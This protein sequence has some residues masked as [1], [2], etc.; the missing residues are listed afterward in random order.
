MIMNNF[1]KFIDSEIGKAI[2]ANWKRTP[3]DKLPGSEPCKIRA[4]FNSSMID[5]KSKM[6]NILALQSDFLLDENIEEQ[7]V[8]LRNNILSENNLLV[9]ICEQVSPDDDNEVTAFVS[10]SLKIDNPNFFCMSCYADND[11]MTT[12]DG[13]NMEDLHEVIHDIWSG[14]LRFSGPTLGK[15]NVNIELMSEECVRC[16]KKIITVTG[17]VFPDI[18]SDKWDNENWQYY[19]QLVPLTALN[20][21]YTQKLKKFIDELRVNDQ[22]ITSLDYKVND[23]IDS[24]YL[25]A[26]CPY[27]N[28]VRGDFYVSDYR[29]HYLHDL[30]SRI[31]KDLQYHSIELDVDNELIETLSAGQELCAHACIM[32]WER[33]K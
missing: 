27:C 17:I 30:T 3:A 9:V 23:L 16:K 8:K 13:E 21:K 15:Q 7:L 33:I 1:L 26:A 28:S 25:T 22:S 11:W 2:P 12:I 14:I 19:N 31:S 20:T 6:I 24:K 4:A 29:M 10:E 5:G 18:Q 32:E